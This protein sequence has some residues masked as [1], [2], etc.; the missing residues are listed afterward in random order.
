MKSKLFAIVGVACA[1][2]LLV[3]SV[4]ACGK[5]APAKTADIASADPAAA[6]AAE[7]AAVDKYMAAHNA[8]NTPKP[9][10]KADLERFGLEFQTLGDQAK[11]NDAALGARCW[12]AA[13]SMRLF[14]ES[15]GLD[16]KDPRALDLATRA[17]AKWREAKSG[18]APIPRPK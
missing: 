13:E 5:K 18:P 9:K 14:A 1:C 11:G 6:F 12:S 10:L 2:G 16:E 8:A 15:L 17:D 3:V 7:I 4:A